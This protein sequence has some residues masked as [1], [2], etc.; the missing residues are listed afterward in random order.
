MEISHETRIRSCRCGLSCCLCQEN[1]VKGI[2][3]KIKSYTFTVFVKEYGE[4]KFLDC[5]ERNEKMGFLDKT[6]M[7]MAAMMLE[8]KNDKSAQDIGM[9]NSIKESYDISNKSRIEPLIE[10]IKSL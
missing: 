4:E 2:L 7:K 1:C 6:M 3:R 5:L 9:Q 8:K 10:Y